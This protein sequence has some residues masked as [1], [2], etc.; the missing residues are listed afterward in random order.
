MIEN[1][2]ASGLD[3]NFLAIVSNGG[4]SVTSLRRVGDTIWQVTQRISARR[5]P[6]SASAASVADAASS[7]GSSEK[8]GKQLH[9]NLP[10]IIQA[11]SSE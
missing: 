5:L 9:D 1:A 10:S 7:A 3:A 11:D 6:L 2:S 8:K 4:A